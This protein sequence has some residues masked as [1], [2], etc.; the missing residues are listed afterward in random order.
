MSAGGQAAERASPRPSSTPP[1]AP[2]AGRGDAAR[3]SPLIKDQLELRR[4]AGAPGQERFEVRYTERPTVSEG[5]RLASRPARALTRPAA[6]QIV[7]I[8]DTLSF[9]KARPICRRSP[10]PY[11]KRWPSPPHV[12]DSRLCAALARRVFSRASARCSC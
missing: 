12:S 4:V 1:Q 10:R 2:D 3:R 9:D 7:P 6:A 8:A 11:G 5:E